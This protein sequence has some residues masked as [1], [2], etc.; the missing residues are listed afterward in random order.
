MEG[1]DKDMKTIDW[2]A[3]RE[4]VLSLPALSRDENNN[5]WDSIRDETEVELFLENLEEEYQQR[6]KQQDAEQNQ[7]IYKQGPSLISPSIY[8][9]LEPFW[10]LPHS[11]RVRRLSAMGALRPLLDEYAPP[12]DRLAFLEQHR[13]TLLEGMELE[14]I[15]KDP[16]GDILG[17]DLKEH[18]SKSPVMMAYLNE[19]DIDVNDR[20][21]IQ[22]IPYAGNQLGR[23]LLMEWNRYKAGRAMYE[24]FL[25]K[26]GKL[27]LRYSD[28]VLPPK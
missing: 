23:A 11:E 10:K 2:D 17:R 19:D 22:V 13:D 16:Q 12:K 14:H 28:T 25:F 24:E 3:T 8:S 6:R 9:W 7:E 26:S 5:F 4:A 21:S 15:V 1:R 20:Y 27:G 18:L